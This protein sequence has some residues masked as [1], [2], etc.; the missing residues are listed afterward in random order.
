MKVF[1]N[2]LELLRHESASSSISLLKKC[3]EHE[4]TKSE[5]EDKKKYLAQM[6]LLNQKTKVR[7]E[8]EKHGKSSQE[9]AVKD[10]EQLLVDH[11]K[12]LKKVESNIHALNDKMFKDSQNLA[13][14][15]RDE[16]NLIAEIKSAQVSNTKILFFL[17]P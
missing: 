4:T 9:Q 11:E 15:R 1:E 5:L 7:L 10:V 13:S 16:F 17:Y 8:Q 2:E 3:N 14:L 12:E 6:G